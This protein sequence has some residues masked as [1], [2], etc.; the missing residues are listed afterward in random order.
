MEDAAIRRGDPLG[1][2]AIAERLADELAPGLSN[3]TRDARWFTILAW[4][5]QQGRAAWH[6]YGDYDADELTTRS[7]TRSLYEWVRPLEA[8]WVARTVLANDGDSQGRQLPGVRSVKRWLYDDTKAER[9][10]F[11]ADSYARYRFTGSYGGY[12]GALRSL[13]GLTI[14]G[15]GWR[16]SDVGNQLAAIAMQHT[17]V[18][19]SHRR[20]KGR[21]PVPDTFWCKAFAWKPQGKTSFLPTLLAEP[22]RLPAGERRPLQRVL[23][24]PRGAG[25]RAK[26]HAARRLLVANAAARSSATTRVALFGDLARAL[27]GTAPELAVLPDFCAI[28][29]AGVLAM[30][31]VWAAVKGGGSDGGMTK[32]GDVV[33]DRDVRDELNA[34]ARASVRWLRGGDRGDWDLRVVDALAS[35]IGAAGDDPD[36]RL[37]ALVRHHRTHGGGRAWVGI[38]NGRVLPLS[39]LRGGQTGHYRFRVGA[40]SRLAVQCGVIDG[41][42]AP[43]VEFDDVEEDDE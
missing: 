35:A 8:L 32:V 22:V 11:S 3:G 33:S 2:R 31:A 18:T 34:L 7:A 17:D 37:R 5:L 10:G 43:Y 19:R 39:P 41:M 29:E 15:D 28:A 1:M 25:E 27:A 42:P 13:H 23:F 20:G 12:R 16:V 30:N 38:G 26:A 36:R 14:D 9:F 21:R 24:E 4:C 6:A 40:L